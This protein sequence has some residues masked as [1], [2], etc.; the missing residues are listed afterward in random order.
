MSREQRIAKEE[1]RL[2][3]LACIQKVTPRQVKPRVSRTKGHLSKRTAFVRDVVKEVSG[4]AFSPPPSPG[5]EPTGP[6]HT[7]RTLLTHHAQPR[8]LRASRYRTPP[9]LQGQARAQAREEEARHLRPW[10]EKGRRDDPRHRREQACWP[11][12]V[13][14]IDDYGRGVAT[15]VDPATCIGVN[16]NGTSNPAS[17][18]MTD[19]SLLIQRNDICLTERLIL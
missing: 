8:P 2:T 4:Y 19:G 15:G 17:L 13:C 16:G 3:R 6:D 10:Q 14:L 1:H 12:S 9:Q 18:R 7:T 11:L 5:L